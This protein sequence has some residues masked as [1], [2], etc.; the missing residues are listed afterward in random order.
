MNLFFYCLTD[1]ADGKAEA[2]KNGIFKRE[3]MIFCCPKTCFPASQVSS[4]CRN[5]LVSYCCITNTKSWWHITV[6]F[7]ALRSICQLGVNLFRL[8][9]SVVVLLYTSL[10]LLESEWKLR[11]VLLVMAEAKK[12]SGEIEGLW[13]PRLGNSTSL[14]L[15]HYIGQSESHGWAQSQIKQEGWGWGA[16]EVCALPLWKEFQ[17]HWQQAWISRVAKNLGA[18]MQF[19]QGRMREPKGA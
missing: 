1:S 4:G 17:S 3:E 6:S 9:L 18:I 10:I 19:T 5:V 16:E 14:C 13:S 2:Y 7:Y 8:C 11:K 15:P 12:A